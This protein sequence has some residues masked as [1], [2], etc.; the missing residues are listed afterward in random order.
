MNTKE[1]ILKII[2]SLVEYS[3]K[4]D[5]LCKCL[6]N[7]SSSETLYLKLTYPIQVLSESVDVVLYLSGIDGKFRISLSPFDLYSFDQEHCTDLLDRI[8]AILDGYFHDYRVGE[9]YSFANIPGGLIKDFF[10]SKRN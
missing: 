9:S 4:F 7:E 1:N 6:E 3:I 2:H 10:N 8:V 5:I